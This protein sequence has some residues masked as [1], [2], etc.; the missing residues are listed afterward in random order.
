MRFPVLTVSFRPD[1]VGVVDEACRAVAGCGPPSL[2]SILA[3]FAVA[4]FFV[5]F[6]GATLHHIREA[7]SV[8]NAERERT[9]AERDA[10]VAFAERIEGIEAT[11]DQSVDV[12]GSV[13]SFAAQP[14]D[15]GLQQ[16]REAYQ[17][18]VMAVPH[19]EDEYDETLGDNLSAELG[20]EVAAAVT[21]GKQLTPRV[22]GTLLQGSA[23]AVRRRDQLL[24]ELANEAE[25][26]ADETDE[27]EPIET[28]LSD[29]SDQS[30]HMR[31]FETL[32]D[33]WN[34]L[35]DLEERCRRVVDRRQGALHRGPNSLAVSRAP[36]LQEY[37][38]GTLSVDHPVIADATDIL[39]RVREARST[40]LDSIVRRA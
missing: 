24:D 33:R 30:P 14:T 18:T 11:P 40:V 3:V 20:E 31:S 25:A 27:L 16:I 28:F 35:I 6:L 15:Q 22:K 5:L 19:Y 37:L 8:V 21:D 9:R 26:L 36:T 38:Y 13:V 4:I 12:G 7:R 23:E 10:F 1:N 34:H 17:A 39:G 29:L 2:L 32:V